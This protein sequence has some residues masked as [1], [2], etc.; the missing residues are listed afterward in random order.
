MITVDKW[1]GL[2]TNAS[3]Y[4]LPPGSAATQV[5]FQCVRPGELESRRGLSSA[6]AITTGATTASRLIEMY[7]FRGLTDACGVV[8]QTNGGQVYYAA[9][10]VGG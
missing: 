4:L 2:I 7:S 5:N 6:A 10:T 9:V 3:P 8:V 1:A